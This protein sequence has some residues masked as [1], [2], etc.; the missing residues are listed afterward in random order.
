[1][2][3]QRCPARLSQPRPYPSVKRRDKPAPPSVSGTEDEFDFLPPARYPCHLTRM[4]RH[5]MSLVMGFL[6]DL[7][8]PQHLEHVLLEH[9]L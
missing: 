4:E 8:D 9:R 2:G 6:F 7:V 1:M 3:I 5:I